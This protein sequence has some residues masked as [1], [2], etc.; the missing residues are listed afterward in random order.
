MQLPEKIAPALASRESV[1][2]NARTGAQVQAYRHTFCG[3]GI[4]AET[5]GRHAG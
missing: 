2:D 3:G 5:V 4:A 1:R